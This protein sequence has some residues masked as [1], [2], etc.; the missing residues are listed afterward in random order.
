MIE[1]STFLILLF[2][3]SSNPNYDVEGSF[4][5]RHLFIY[6][7]TTSLFRRIYNAYLEA[8][9]FHFPKYRTQPEKEH[10][11][12][13]KAKDLNGRDS[14]QLSLLVW[15]DLG[16]YLS[17][18][19]LDLAV[20][21]LIPGFYPPPNPLSPQTFPTRFLRLALNH[22]LMSFG[23]YWLHR[24]S[25]NVPL[26]WR[27]HAV[28]HWSKHPLSRNTYEDHWIDNLSNALV[29]HLC[30]QIILPLDLPTFALSHLLRIA[31]SLE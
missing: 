19:A 3:I 18:T 25:H 8:C 31:E 29:G 9:Y 6:F 10:L 1:M 12:I 28:H 5:L 23:M 22:L 7:L 30:A 27:V 20:Y 17:T 13:K 4:T 2:F 26:L 24:S 15:H 21:Y 16:T 14:K 11:L